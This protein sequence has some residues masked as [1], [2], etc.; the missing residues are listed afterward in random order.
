MESVTLEQR[1]TNKRKE[2]TSKRKEQRRNSTAPLGRYK[3]RQEPTKTQ[4]RAGRVLLLTGN[5]QQNVHPLAS[6]TGKY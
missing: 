3:G 1:Q 6:Y 2:D 4:G 5:K